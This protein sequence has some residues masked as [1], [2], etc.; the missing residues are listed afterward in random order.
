[1]CSLGP[2]NAHHRLSHFPINILYKEI[3]ENRRIKD[4]ISPGDLAEIGDERRYLVEGML[5][6]LNE[7]KN[8][9]VREN[10]L[11]ALYIH[12]LRV[13]NNGN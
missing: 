11:H 4:V 2:F 12:T 3:I 13:L 9:N 10:P 1:M 8:I 5:C 6:T 7:E